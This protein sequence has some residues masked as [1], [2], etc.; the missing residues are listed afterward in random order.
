[1]RRGRER[2][3]LGRKEEGRRVPFVGGTSDPNGADREGERGRRR[4]EPRRVQGGGCDYWPPSFNH[5]SS[6]R[7]GKGGNKEGGEGERKG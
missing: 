5:H 6:D 2:K 7:E 3:R 4:E 1:V